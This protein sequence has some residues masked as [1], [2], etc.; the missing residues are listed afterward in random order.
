MEGYHLLLKRVGIELG[1]V[2]VYMFW[3]GLSMIGQHKCLIHLRK[4]LRKNI[5]IAAYGKQE[6]SIRV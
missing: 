1:Y 4:S 6:P 3:V 2:H 5:I